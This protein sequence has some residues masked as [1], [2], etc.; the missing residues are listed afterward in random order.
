MAMPILSAVTTGIGFASRVS[1]ARAE[2]AALEA[3]ARQQQQLYDLQVQQN[4][5]QRLDAE[6]QYRVDSQTVAEQSRRQRSRSLLEFE[7]EERDRLRKLRLASG[8]VAATTA[9]RGVAGG[10]SAAAIQRGLESRA[11]T[12]SDRAEADLAEFERRAAYDEALNA[13]DLERQRYMTSAGLSDTAQ[14]GAIANAWQRRQNLLD[15]SERRARAR[16]GLFEDAMSSGSTIVR[17]LSAV[18]TGG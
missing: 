4:E 18:D 3:R 2:E 17:Q 12:A 8:S 6:R 15:L 16:L 13:Y 1:Q 11:D 9:A 10:G 5:R 7:R 14:R